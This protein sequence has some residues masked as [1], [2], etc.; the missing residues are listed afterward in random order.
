M[1]PLLYLT[2]HWKDG[3]LAMEQ[4]CASPPH[5]DTGHRPRTWPARVAIL[6]L[7]PPVSELLT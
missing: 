5:R 4:E 2:Q 1:S 3:V 7:Q 6:S